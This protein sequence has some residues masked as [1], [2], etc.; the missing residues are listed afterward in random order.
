MLRLVV[1][2]QVA[3]GAVV[4]IRTR[5]GARPMEAKAKSMPSG[6]GDHFQPGGRLAS[7]A[8]SLCFRNWISA[9]DSPVVA[10]SRSWAAFVR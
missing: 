4:M 8:I 5:P 7:R 10:P 1:A 6:A 3:F 2:W 9:V